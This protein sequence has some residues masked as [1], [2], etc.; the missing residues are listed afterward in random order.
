M[1]RSFYYTALIILLAVVFH[2]CSTEKNTRASRAYHNVTSKY[3]IYFNGKESMKAGLKR[4]EDN[5]QDDFTRILPVYIE[6]YPSA[7]NTSRADMDNTILKATKLIQIHSITKK[8]KRQRIRTRAYQQFASQEEFNKWVD[9]SYLLMGKAY[10]Y[11]HNF[12]SAAENFSLVTRKFPQGKSR[13][14]ALVWLMR[15]YSEQERYAEAREIMLAM[16]SDRL[17]PRKLEKELAKVAADMFLKQKEYQEALKYLDIALKKSHNGKEKARLQYIM[18]QLYLETGNEAKASEAYRAVGKYNAPYKMAFN[19]R[20]NAAGMFSGQ[21]DPE[22]LKKELRKLLRDEKNLE[23]RDQIYFALGNIFFKEGNQ[24]KAIENWRESVASS[25]DNDQQLALSAVTLAD[26]YFQEKSYKEAQA[27]YDSAVMVLNEDYPGYDR[28]SELHGSLTRLVDQLTV[29]EVQDS[30]QKLALMPEAER[31]QLIGKWIADLKEKERQDELIAARQQSQAGYYRSNEYRFGLGRSSE[32]GGWYFYNPQTVS[33]GKAQFQQQWGRRKLEDNWRRMNKQTVSDEEYGEFAD[34]ADST[35]A[36]VRETDPMEKAFYTQDLPLNDSLMALSHEKIRDALYNAGRIFK[37]D[38]SDYPRAAETL[39]NLNQRYPSNIYL[40]SAWFELYDAYELMGDHA[41]ALEYRDL[42]ISRYPDSKYAQYLQNPNFFAEAEARKQEINMIYQETFREYKAGRYQEVLTRIAGM[43]K[44]DPDSALMPKIDFM[45]TIA[46]GAGNDM[47]AL[48][49]KL[50]GYITTYPREEPTPLAKEILTLISDSTL[51]DYQKLVDMGYLHDEIRNEEV[52]AGDPS[53]NDEFGGK[54]SYDEDLLH[55]FVIVYPRAAGIDIN[56]LKFDIANYNLD[57]YT[58]LDFDLAE[59][60]L[61]ASTNLLTVRS[62]ANKE[63]G[64]IYFRAIIR[65]PEV[66]RTLGT[67]PYHNFIASST[68]YRQILADQSAGDYLRFFLKNYSRFIGPDFTPEDQLGE[69]PEELMARA[70]REDEILQEK[71]RFVTVDVPVVS[72]MFDTHTDTTQNFVLA[73][74]DKNLPIRTMLN[75]FADFNRDQFRIWNLALQI[76]QAGDYQLMVVRGLPGFTESLSYFRK[77][78]L[79]RSLFRTLGQTTYRNFIITDENLA[80]LLEKG[81]V[82]G[83][84]EFFRAKYIQQASEGSQVPAA[85]GQ[86]GSSRAPQ[87]VPASGSTLT[88]PGGTAT[89]TSVTPAEPSPAVKPSGVTPTGRTGETTGDT[90]ARAVAT[91]RAAEPAVAYS[92]AYNQ[93]V[94]GDHYYLIIVPS[95]GFAR[96]TFTAALAAFCQEELPGAG[97]TVDE[98]PLDDFRIMVRVLGFRGK[99]EA[100]AFH[101]RVTARRSLF[102]PLGSLTYRNFM[103]TPENYNIFLQRKNITEYLDFY[104]IA[105]PGMP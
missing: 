19:A 69:T 72:G 77:V 97:I 84:L 38:F 8:P 5:V 58:R 94:E 33:Y 31:E 36:V 41:R 26:L 44:M 83:Y 61:D 43:K 23:F 46:L 67:T 20:I 79:E 30:L 89:S 95:Q 82:N 3:N 62:L 11:Q 105:Y 32:G 34:L 54:F 29:V 75:Q 16:E 91:A 101:G 90:V 7:G 42:I 65:Q 64:L 88:A 57:H 39:T 48:G 17:F 1:K 76:K 9:D 92:G 60:A 55:Y 21:G 73:V 68:N 63:Q 74:M 49:E 25:V 51:A 93:H 15:S 85:P 86:P 59:E 13:Y 103:I 47:A 99:T 35:R 10:F 52:T 78:I 100:A 28:L 14:E 45:E 40:L 18:A 27:Y 96:E 53:E 4:I 102:A 80:R 87:G 66:F 24:E 104:K 6:S 71:G 98:Q 2:G 22:E 50:K 37:S 56:R 70:Q 12:V 81:D